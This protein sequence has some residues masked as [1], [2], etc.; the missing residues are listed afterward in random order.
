MGYFEEYDRERGPI[1]LNKSRIN[2]LK[3]SEV[4]EKQFRKKE[5]RG[6]QNFLYDPKL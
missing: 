2:G 5:K 4:N 3:V 1:D 6:F